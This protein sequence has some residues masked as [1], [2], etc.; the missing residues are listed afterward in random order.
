MPQ[1]TPSQARV[2]NPVLSSIAR[3]IQQND[4]VGGFLFPRVDVPLRGG[5]I[6][7]F[8]REAFMQYSNLNRAPGSSTPRVQFGYSGSAYSLIDYSIEGKVPIEIQ[9]EG[10]NSSFTLDH[11]A[12]AI[13]GADRILALRLE[14]AQATL[15]TTLGNHASSNRVT[16]TS[17]AQWSDQ[18]SGVSNPL[19]NIETGKEAIRAGTGKRPNVGVMGPA[20]WASLKYHPIL[21]DYTKYTGREVAT[22]GI[23]SELTGIPNWYVGD[24]VF[25][26]DDGTVLSDC[27]GKDVVMAYSELGSVASYGAPTFGYTYNLEGY[28]LAEEPYMDRNVKSQMFPV[29]RAE[30]PVIAGQLAGYLIKAAVA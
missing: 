19:A 16:L 26:N 22:L 17:T 8:G 23:L 1:L 27:W 21:R 12:V 29:T 6:L 4:L 13:N 2:I 5:Q 24:A 7:T 10:M 3:G 9:E 25:S 14:I 28:P 20:V 15:A 11:A 18:T 30:A